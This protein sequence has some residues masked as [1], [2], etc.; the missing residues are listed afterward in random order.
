MVIN[1][2]I[3]LTRPQATLAS[4]YSCPTFFL[5]GICQDG[6]FDEEYMKLENSIMRSV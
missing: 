4:F 5:A 1:T 2:G 3:A 6:S